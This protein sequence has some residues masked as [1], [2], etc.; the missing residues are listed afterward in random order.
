MK[1][2]HLPVVS[3]KTFRGEQVVIDGKRFENCKF[4]ECTL[5]YSGGPAETS[6]CEFGPNLLW[7]FQEPVGTSLTVLQQFGWRFEFGAKGPQAP[8]IQVP[9]PKQQ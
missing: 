2:F 1:P 7:G 4:F 3:N 9:T 6:S 8:A 5:I